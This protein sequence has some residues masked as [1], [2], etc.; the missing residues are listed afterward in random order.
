[1]KYMYLFLQQD[2]IL[3]LFQVCQEINPTDTDLVIK[4]SKL[5]V[6]VL[7][8]L[9]CAD[10]NILKNTISWILLCIVNLKNHQLHSEKINEILHFYISTTQTYKNLNINNEKVRNYLCYIFLVFFGTFIFY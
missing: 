10:E 6:K 4:C 8:K 3:C 9:G 2:D 5:L 1:M 7:P